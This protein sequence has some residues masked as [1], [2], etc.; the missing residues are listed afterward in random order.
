MLFN[1][2]EYFVFF[3]VVFSYR[4]YVHPLLFKS[5]EKGRN[6]LHVFLLISSYF[7]YMSWDY[8]FGALIFISTLIDY[9]LAISIEKSEEHSKRFNLLQIS[10]F[11]NLVAILGF[12]KYYNFACDNVNS[13][14]FL[15]GFE[16]PLPELKIILP[17][18]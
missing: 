8:R 5:T 10:L 16:K 13:L 9:I 2:L 17:V 3:T 4:W 15:L 11:L 14:F 7:F 12:F 6:L 18:G 1:T